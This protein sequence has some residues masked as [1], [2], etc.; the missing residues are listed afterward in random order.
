[1]NWLKKSDDLHFGD[2]YKDADYV[3]NVFVLSKLKR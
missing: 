1:M 3:D 2:S